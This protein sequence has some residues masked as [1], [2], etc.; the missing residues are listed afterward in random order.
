MLHG[1]TGRDPGSRQGS[2]QT[3]ESS[4]SGPGFRGPGTA[5]GC[6]AREVL[7]VFTP[8]KQQMTSLWKMTR[9]QITSRKL[10]AGSRCAGHN[11]GHWHCPSV[12]LLTPS[13]RRAGGFRST[14]RVG[15]TVTTSLSRG[16]RFHPLGPQWDSGRRVRWPLG[17]HS[18]SLTQPRWQ[19]ARDCQ[20]LWSG[21]RDQGP[22]P[23]LAR[24]G[25]SPW[26]L[27]HHR[28]CTQARFLRYICI[29]FLVRTCG[30]NLL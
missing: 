24:P 23:G 3:L 11:P 21:T 4:D 17:A 20:G 13:R 28:V 16:L 30:P 10:K 2:G 27:V 9:T 14:R 26:S 19:G 15:V 29:A 1:L 8:L 12:A 7:R 18:A 6:S 5:G 22:A 25:A